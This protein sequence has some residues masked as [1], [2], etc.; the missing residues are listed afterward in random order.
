MINYLVPLAGA[1]SGHEVKSGGVNVLIEE[2]PIITAFDQ[3]TP[4]SVVIENSGQSSIAGTAQLRELVDET[5]AVGE[6]RKEFKLESGKKIKIEY[7]ISMGK[8]ACSALYPAHVY[9]DFKRDGVAGETIHAVRIFE[10]QF[11]KEVAS[12]SAS[13]AAASAAAPFDAS[14]VPRQG[15]LPLWSLTTFRM[16][17]Q[18]FD[19]P[20]QY[21]P[22]GWTGSDRV[23]KADL[24]FVT[25]AR[26]ESK[27]AIVMHPPYG[28]GVGTVFCEY[29]IKLPATTPLRLSFFNA[30][31]DTGPA[32][33]P[34]DGVLFRVWAA[35]PGSQAPGKML[36]ENFTKAKTWAPGEANLDEFAGQA[37]LLRLESHPGPQKNTTCDSSFWGE[38]IL[39]AGAKPA[40]LSADAQAAIAK[41]NEALGRAILEG[42]AQADNQYSF[43]LGKDSDRCAAIVKP[44]ASGIVDGVFTLVGAKSSVTFQGLRVDVLN[45]P[46]VRWPSPYGFTGYKVTRQN[47]RALHVHQMEKDGKPMELT[48]ALWAEGDGL[49][50]ALSCAERI[51]DFSLGSADRKAPAVYFGHGYRIQN[52]EA[53]SVGFGGHALATSHVGADYEGGMS[54][55]QA[56]DNP[57]D[58]FQV[59][60]AARQ[61]ALHSHLD[62]TLT[63]VAGEKG[64]FDC[65]FRYRPLY[66]KKPADGVARLAGRYCFDIWGGRYKDIAT[67]MRLAIQ[68]GLTD[69][70]LTIHNWQRWGYDYRLPDIWPPQPGLGT[71]EDMREIGA[72]CNARDIPW[73]L[74]DNYIDFYPDAASYS[75]DHIAFTPKGDPIKAWLNEGRK[76]QSYRWRPDR[77][78]PF[79]K[80]NLQL[81]KEGVAPTHYFIDVFTSIN[82]FDFYDRQGKFHP[83]TETRA[84]WGESF[85][86]IRDYLGGH[87]PMTSEAGDDQLTGWLDGADCQHITISKDGGEFL[88]RVPCEDWERVPWFDAVNH[89]RFILFGAGYSNRY[90][91][92]RGRSEHG[93][94]SDDYISDE[95][96]TGHALMTDAGSW[97]R[98]AVRKYWLA[99]DVARALAMKEITNVEMSGGDM[100]RQIV[101]WSN[102]VKAY[103]NRGA[104]DWQIEGA[105]LPNY[106]YRLTGPEGLM[107]AIEKRDGVFCESAGGPSGWYCNARAFEGGLPHRIQ[108][109][110]ENF[111]YLGDR[112]FQWDVVWQAEE[113]APRPMTIFVHFFDPTQTGRRRDK[114]VFQDDHKPAPPSNEWKGAVRYTRTVTIPEDADGSY[115]VGF[116]LFDDRSRLAMTGQAVP[117]VGQDTLWAGTIRAQR[118]GGAVSKIEF[119]PPTEAPPMPPLRINAERKPVDFGFAVTNG[120]MRI[121]KTQNGL[122]VIPLPESKP[123]EM[124][125]RIGAF[126][127]KAAAAAAPATVARVVAVAQDGSASGETAFTQKDQAVTLRHDG[128]SFAYDLSYR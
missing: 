82:L 8:G 105:T 64:A 26:G 53:F 49:R 19:K 102:G 31:R 80:R 78:M 55:L 62:G 16:A 126:Q 38:P 70:F 25:I 112:R 94:N 91:G 97:G 69:S 114:I 24:G 58:R 1:W 74:H 10:T 42:K 61:Y 41:E 120:A 76:A 110:I 72:L 7:S 103:V 40:S 52:P 43:L 93:I 35:R 128:V 34:S 96:L 51:T 122:R 59:N 71:L 99:Q 23:S 3:A 17:W 20:L 27:P 108:M 86:W 117:R 83:S 63:L 29:L 65:A 90:E 88:M 50:I 124:T 9:V 56:V 2:I 77:F 119:T 18:Y 104:G 45:Q 85:A 113:P 13:A 14:I 47:G 28:G 127:G 100:H 118:A 89:S 66:D 84:R 101:T 68:Y 123:F 75:Y 21:K 4:V 121:Q 37:I 44:T 67:R 48:L 79:L 12:A 95:I 107:S 98:Q 36:F 54:V 116:G 111:R 73:G 109:K 22:A 81:I 30:I 46:A 106:G 33:P 57:P 60:P 92:G 15:A 5:R 115:P 11:P 125:L 6:T 32:E 39:S 87:A